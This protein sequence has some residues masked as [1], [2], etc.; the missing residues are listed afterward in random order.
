MAIIVWA[1]TKEETGMEE[2]V[3]IR[4]TIEKGTIVAVVAV[5]VWLTTK[6]E[7]R[8]KETVVV[9]KITIQVART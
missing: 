6:E 2:A 8:T 3:F 5:V 4:I 1:T 9:Q 7:K